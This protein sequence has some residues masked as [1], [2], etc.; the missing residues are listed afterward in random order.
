MFMGI[1]SRFLPDRSD[2]H[3]TRREPRPRSVP[4]G[5]GADELPR[6]RLDDFEDPPRDQPDVPFVEVDR[7]LL[8]DVV[9]LF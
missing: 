6:P 1:I 9:V 7:S 8:I 3:L 2:L 5:K 4:G